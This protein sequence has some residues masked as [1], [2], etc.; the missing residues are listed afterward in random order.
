MLYLLQLRARTRGDPR[1]RALIDQC[2]ALYCRSAETED[3]GLDE[4]DAEVRAVGDELALRFG[5]P[6]APRRNRSARPRGAIM[7]PAPGNGSIRLA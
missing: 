5:P 7:A 2:L 3:A 1:S 4:L 6:K